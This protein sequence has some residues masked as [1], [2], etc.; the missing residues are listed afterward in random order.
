MYNQIKPTETVASQW[1]AYAHSICSAAV[2]KPV[3]AYRAQLLPESNWLP[4]VTLSQEDITGLSPTTSQRMPS[5][6]RTF[7]NR[8]LWRR[9]SQISR[10]WIHATTHFTE[11]RFR[12]TP[13]S[14]V[15]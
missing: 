12:S 3:G 1:L 15:C 8:L 7:G 4:A 9:Q 5:I 14:Q 2:H 13:Q 10:T 11:L 6:R